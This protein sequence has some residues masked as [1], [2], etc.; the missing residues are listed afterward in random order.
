MSGTARNDSTAVIG[1]R[2]FWQI[3]KSLTQFNVARPIPP[4]KT[5]LDIEN[6]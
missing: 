3:S 5:E 1:I 2:E 4:D 6:V